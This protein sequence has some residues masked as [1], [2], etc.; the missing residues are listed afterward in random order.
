MNS[1]VA[2][3]ICR[4]NPW[5]TSSRLKLLLSNFLHRLFESLSF[6][7]L[8]RLQALSSNFRTFSDISTFFQT[9]LLLISSSTFSDLHRFSSTCKLL[10]FHIP[11]Q[12]IAHLLITRQCPSPLY[13]R[14]HLHLLLPSITSEPI[15]ANP[16][17]PLLPSRLPANPSPPLLP[18]APQLLPSAV[19]PF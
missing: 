10:T 1:M 18:F 8:T 14:T 4:F 6:L 16:S 15:S 5:F 13:Q 19:L 12:Q 3:L 11:Y 9:S 7:L 2:P 17:P